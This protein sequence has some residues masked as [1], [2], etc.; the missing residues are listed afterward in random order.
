MEWELPKRSALCMECG[1]SFKK[2][3]QGA[4]FLKVHMHSIRR[5]DVCEECALKK[6]GDADSRSAL[7]Q[8]TRKKEE[9][10]ERVSFQELV[11]LLF[12]LES[13][14]TDQEKF[15]LAHVFLTLR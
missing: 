6:K 5:V 8:W 14:L 11:T 10:P 1:V 15:V 13:G 12:S 4:T 9:M 7:W 3:A 2:K